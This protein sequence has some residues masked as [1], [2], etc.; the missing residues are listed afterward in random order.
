V[1]DGA[2]SSRLMEEHEKLKE[3][4]RLMQQE[5]ADLKS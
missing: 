2:A 4:H 5:V 3:A 1:I